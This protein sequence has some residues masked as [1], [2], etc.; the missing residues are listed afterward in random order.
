VVDGHIETNFSD[1]S[2]ADMLLEHEGKL[3][4]WESFASGRAIVARYGKRAEDIHDDATWQKIVRELRSGF[5][6]LIAIMEPDA[7]VVGGSVGNFFERFEKF[8]QADLK[9]YETPLLHIPTLYKAQRPEEAVIFGC[10]DLAKATFK[11]SAKPK[12]KTTKS[13]AKTT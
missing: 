7:I 6:E 1:N 3:V 13:H 2:G 12:P 5:L 4:P 9:A 11:K 10:Y 8:L